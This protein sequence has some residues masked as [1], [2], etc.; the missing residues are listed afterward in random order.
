MQWSALTKVNRGYTLVWDFS[1]QASKIFKQAKFIFVHFSPISK[2]ITIC[3]FD[4]QSSTDQT[5]I[6]S[7]RKMLLIQPTSF[8]SIQKDFEGILNFLSKKDIKSLPGKI[9]L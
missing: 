9:A 1:K 6:V 3:L 2:K 8:N 5:V 7:S 4:N